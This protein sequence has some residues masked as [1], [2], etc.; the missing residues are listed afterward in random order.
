MPLAPAVWCNGGG[1]PDSRTPP[2]IWT[3]SP[4]VPACRDSGQPWRSPYPFGAAGE[5]TGTWLRV[6]RGFSERGMPLALV[7]NSAVGEAEFE[8][9]Q[10]ACTADRRPQL[11]RSEVAEVVRRI[12]HAET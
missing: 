4:A 7:S 5:K 1:R 11:A 3:P 9:W 8:A 6:A 2:Q 12:K 10:R